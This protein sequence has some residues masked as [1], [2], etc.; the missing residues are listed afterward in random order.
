DDFQRPSPWSSGET[1]AD[2]F[3]KRV[4]ELTCTSDELADFARECGAPG[5]SKPGEERR[6]QLR[7]ELDAACFGLF[8]L[9]RDEFEQVM[10]NFE[11]LERREREQYGRFVSRDKTLAILELWRT[12]EG[13]S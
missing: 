12:A 3:I 4:V 6:L 2:W 5:T 8:R 10:R 13:K 7:A 11:V 1:L 9:C